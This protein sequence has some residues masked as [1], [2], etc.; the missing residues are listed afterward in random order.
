MVLVVPSRTTGRPT[1]Y[2]P[3]VLVKWVRCEVVDR[4]GFDRGQQSW[5]ELEE[6]RGFLGQHGGWG[7][8]RGGT[9]TAH[10]VTFW[11]DPD[12]YERF[13][14]GP[15]D[16]LAAGQE[17]AFGN[18]DV[19]IFEHRQDIGTSV[20]NAPA[21]G[22]FRLAH[23]WV[24]S[25]RIDHF[26]HVQAIEWNPGM[27]EFPGFLGGVFGQRGA[28]EFLVLTA[29]A[30]KVAHARYQSERFPVLRDRAV[31]FADL[32]TITGHVIELEPRWSVRPRW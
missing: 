19:R 10:V 12:S 26:T 5:T 15:H 32:E 28:R 7:S 6:L 31:P 17:G 13:M 11:S 8:D 4:V 25:H 16:T 27:S 18:I 20:V 24:Q 23:C 22:A 1:G 9:G 29:W 30:S 2:G 14:A 3:E 21:A